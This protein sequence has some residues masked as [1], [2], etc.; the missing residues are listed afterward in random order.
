MKWA[1]S[2]DDRE[3]W[4]GPHTREAALA[5]AEQLA[6]E[7]EGSAF[8]IAPVFETD[9][10]VHGP[11]ANE[12]LDYSWESIRD[13]VRSDAEELDVS[14]EDEAALQVMLS[15]A[16]EAWV[17]MR[18]ITCSAFTVDTDR[19]E[20]FALSDGAVVPV[21]PELTKLAVAL[22][23]IRSFIADPS[24]PTTLDI[25]CL[26]ELVR[27]FDADHVMLEPG[28]D[29]GEIEGALRHLEQF[30]VGNDSE[31]RREEA[32]AAAVNVRKLLDRRRI[33]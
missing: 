7:G 9:L 4:E 23:S 2:I 15:H 27:R 10:R 25:G 24:A 17:E 5:E 14:D 29:I 31:R 1:Y 22:E 33:R 19:A 6:R 20:T 30:A 21:E 16:W 18:G 26:I 13:N 8:A 32:R 12:V 3:T 28:E 11:D